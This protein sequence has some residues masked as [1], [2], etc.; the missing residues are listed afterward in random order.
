VRRRELQLTHLG[1]DGRV[2]RELQDEHVEV[3]R[4]MKRR[5]RPV[6]VV[7]LDDA[8]LPL[9]HNGRLD[10]GHVRGAAGEVE[11]ANARHQD[12]PM[13]I[14]GAMTPEAASYVLQ[15][16][17]AFILKP[18]V[19]TADGPAAN[20]GDTVVVTPNG[21]RRLGKDKHE[22]VVR[23]PAFLL[24]WASAEALLRR[25]ALEHGVSVARLS[26]T[27]FVKELA[28]QGLLERSDY[29]TLEKAASFRSGFAHG[30]GAH[31]LD[32][33]LLEKLLSVIEGLREDVEG[34]D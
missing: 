1:L 15:E 13:L 28:T 2:A 20:W 4:T 26:P 6:G 30:I 18:S 21:G 33:V 11:G 27:Q 32:P 31:K 22:L 19:R 12:R 29:V 9:P 25:M 3:R 7:R 24:L 14:G 10:P 23:E 5:L 17:N 34:P 8:I 16:G